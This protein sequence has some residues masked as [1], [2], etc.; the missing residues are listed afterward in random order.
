MWA[1]SNP[2]LTFI[3][4]DCVDDANNRE[5]NSG[6]TWC[7]DATA[8]Y[9]G[10]CT[11]AAEDYEEMG[12]SIYPNPTNTILYIDTQAPIDSVSIYSVTGSFIKQTFNSN[13]NVADL[14]GGLYIVKIYIE[15]NSITKKFLKF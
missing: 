1:Y 11:L 13:I 9:I 14:P 12:L 3:T 5:C 4:V 8:S 2:D 6:F 7:K 15:G 10:E